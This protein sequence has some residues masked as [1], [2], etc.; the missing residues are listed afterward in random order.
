MPC[1]MK[2][3]LEQEQG[4]GDSHATDQGTIH[5][6]ELGLGRSMTRNASKEIKHD[7][8]KI[9]DYGIGI[10]REGNATCRNM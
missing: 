6:L 9:E 3:P 5:F 7:P 4:A 8:Y 1:E 2:V 10:R